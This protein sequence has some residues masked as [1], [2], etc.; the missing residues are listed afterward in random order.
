MTSAGLKQ[1]ASINV[2]D[3][4]MQRGRERERERDGSDIHDNKCFT[5]GFRSNIFN[6]VMILYRI[7]LLVIMMRRPGTTGFEVYDRPGL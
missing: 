5:N 2:G 1:V 4:G 7:E 6:T 3:S